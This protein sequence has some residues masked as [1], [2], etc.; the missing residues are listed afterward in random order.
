MKLITKAI[1]AKLEKNYREHNDENVV[2]KLFGGSNCTWLITQIAPDGDTLSGIA[3]IGHG[4]CEYGTM[5]LSELQ[6]IRFPPFRLGIERDMY[7][8]GGK[9]NDFLNYYEEKHTLNGC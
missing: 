9:V 2:L 4:T 8:K 6:A 7:F 3:D 5:S 1:C